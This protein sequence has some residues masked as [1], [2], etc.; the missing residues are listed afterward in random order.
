V[1]WDLIFI[2]STAMF[3]GGTTI[4]CN[5]MPV[6]MADEQVRHATK[7]I[8]CYN[9]CWFLLII[10]LCPLIVHLSV[11]RIAYNFVYIFAWIFYTETWKCDA[12]P[13]YT[14]STPEQIF[15]SQI[16]ASKRGVLL[17]LSLMTDLVC[18]LSN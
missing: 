5:V 18:V 10:S 12:K 3:S 14:L 4:A 8:K 9:L 11:I 16:R 15:P 7:S 6:K 17:R 1:F 2:A 13:S